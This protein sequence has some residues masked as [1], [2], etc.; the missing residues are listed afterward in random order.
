MSL[1]KNFIGKAR[2]VP[3]ANAGPSFLRAN[4]TLLLTVYCRIVRVDIVWILTILTTVHLNILR[5]IAD[6][7]AMHLVI[8]RYLRLAQVR[9]AVDIVSQLVVGQAHLV[10]NLRRVDGR[11]RLHLLILP[12]GLDLSLIRINGQVLLLLRQT[13][14]AP[15]IL[16]DFDAPFPTALL[17]G[18]VFI[19][20]YIRIGQAKRLMFIAFHVNFIIAVNLYPFSA[21][22]IP[23][24]DFSHL[25]VVGLS[26]F[27][28][29]ST[30]GGSGWRFDN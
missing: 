4:S 6:I 24:H 28:V 17:R 2:I 23:G 25:G 3:V 9:V 14:N 13:V 7:L 1:I 19:W 20:C 29:K 10:R 15:V 22:D 21:S 30:E 18:H 8:I 12:C 16:V 26:A 27:T 5:E 11:K